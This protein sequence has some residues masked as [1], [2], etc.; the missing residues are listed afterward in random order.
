MLDTSNVTSK[1]QEL[2]LGQ[3]WIRNKIHNS[4]YTP[5]FILFLRDEHGNGFGHDGQDIF[6][7]VEV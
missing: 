3:G 1:F 4:R 6:V 2:V 7:E 5:L